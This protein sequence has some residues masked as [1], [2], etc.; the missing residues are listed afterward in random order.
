MTKSRIRAR[1]ANYNFADRPGPA[2][3]RALGARAARPGQN[4]ARAAILQADLC[5]YIYI[6]MPYIF[7]GPILL[8]C[9]MLFLL[10]CFFSRFM[11]IVSCFLPTR[12]SAHGNADDDSI[13][14]PYRKKEGPNATLHSLSEKLL[15]ATKP[16]CSFEVRC[17]QK[18]TLALQAPSHC[19]SRLASV[20]QTNRNQN[21]S[22][23]FRGFGQ[24]GLAPLNL[25]YLAPLALFGLLWVLWD[26]FWIFLCPL[27]RPQGTFGCP[28]G[29]FG[30]TLAVLGA[31][32]GCPCPV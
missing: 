18:K 15:S 11:I 17:G 23:G 16:D 8:P 29:S 7:A 26:D 3:S 24:V 28:L 22:P 5:T 10:P 32:S 6:Y 25:R 27:G 9:F 21:L 13:G 12:L 19:R 30:L 20:C 2:Q 4:R 1:S 31:F 14:A